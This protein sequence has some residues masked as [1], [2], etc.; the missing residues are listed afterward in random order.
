M[1]K[2]Y[3]KSSQ[4]K[5][6]GKRA[7]TFTIYLSSLL[8]STQNIA[9]N[10]AF[11][12]SICILYLP[13]LPFR[14]LLSHNI[15]SIEV[16]AQVEKYAKVIKCS[17]TFFCIKTLLCRLWVEHGV[18]ACFMYSSSLIYEDLCMGM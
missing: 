5:G 14:F 8:H 17:Y 3:G 10:T 18:R 7:L 15:H 1:E 4:P 6:K 13:L 2:D 16:A 12:S 9:K 11:I